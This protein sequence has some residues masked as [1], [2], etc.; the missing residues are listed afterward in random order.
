M[1]HA[2]DSAFNKPGNIIA[3]GAVQITKVGV[4]ILQADMPD[5]EQKQYR[6]ADRLWREFT[7]YG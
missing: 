7:I 3:A 2:T 4:D 5:Q 6:R 1:S